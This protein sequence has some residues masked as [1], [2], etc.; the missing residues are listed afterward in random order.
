MEQKSAKD[1]SVQGLTDRRKWEWG[2]SIGSGG[3]TSGEGIE[4]DQPKFPENFYTYKSL[5]SSASDFALMATEKQVELAEAQEDKIW[6]FREPPV[7]RKAPA[8]DNSHQLFHMKGDWDYRKGTRYLCDMNHDGYPDYLVIDDDNSPDDWI[9]F[10]NKNG[11]FEE[12]TVSFVNPYSD[13]SRPYLG[14]Y[15]HDSDGYTQVRTMLI[16]VNNDS[17]QDVV[18]INNMDKSDVWYVGI[19]KI[20]TENSFNVIKWKMPE[21]LPISSGDP[22][23]YNCYMHRGLLDINGDGYPDYVK[24]ESNHWTVYYGEGISGFMLN[25]VTINA[26]PVPL[27]WQLRGAP[28]IDTTLILHTNCSLKTQIISWHH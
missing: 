18:W 25:S 1:K 9:I 28:I 13:V 2:S 16:D 8:V 11:E 6:G 15:H 24:A 12:K 21:S 26:Q 20:P 27:K 19:N 4:E 10:I 22:G 14:E 5:Y 17:L 23:D 7:P 3:G